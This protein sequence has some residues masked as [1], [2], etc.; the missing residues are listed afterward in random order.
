[1][2][3]KGVRYLFNSIKGTE[4]KIN[5]DNHLII[6]SGFQKLFFLFDGVGGSM[7]GKKATEL[8]IDFIKNNYQRYLANNDYDTENLFAD[9]NIFILNSGIEDALTTISC[10]II[11]IDKETT[12][13]ISNLGDT[14]IYSFTFQ[15]IKKI[16]IDDRV[17]LR[18]NLITKCLGMREL[19]LNDVHKRV[20]QSNQD[21]FLLCTDGFY[22]LLEN[23]KNQFLTALNTDGDKIAI[24]RLNKLIDGKNNDDS[25][26]IVVYP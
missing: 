6:D 14:R 23:Q 22:N 3:D 11:L 15:T 21:N 16:S 12:F 20:F 7:N 18:D 25:T 17:P 10:L 1:M 19:N 26:F 8:A 9:T 13:V 5:E 4:R 24:N 2:N